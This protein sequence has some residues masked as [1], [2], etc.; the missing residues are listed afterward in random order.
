MPRDERPRR[1][2]ASRSFGGRAKASRQARSTCAS[3]SSPASR[4][5]RAAN[6]SA[7]FSMNVLFDMDNAWTGV[8]VRVR[9]GVMTDG[10]G[11]SSV[12]SRG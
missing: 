6:C 12:S 1:A 7:H 10:S 2:C 4:R 5:T 3:A 9:L 11:Q 8:I